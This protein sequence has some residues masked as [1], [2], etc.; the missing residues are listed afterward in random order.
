MATLESS[1]KQIALAFA[2]ALISGKFDSAHEMLIEEQ[3]LEWSASALQARYEEMI[4]YADAPPDETRL[5]QTLE[6]WPGRLSGDLGWAY[7]AINGY[8]FGEAVAVVVTR[9][10]G[11]AR[12][13]MIEW[14]RP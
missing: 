6:E 12:I 7:V 2:E 11:A 13:R 3:K 1:Y 8:C 10:N 9:E 14:G 4:D 5:M